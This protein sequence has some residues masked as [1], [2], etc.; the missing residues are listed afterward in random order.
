MQIV[1]HVQGW[2][3]ESGG[4]RGKSCCVVRWS[5]ACSL[6]DS[7]LCGSREIFISQ[8][9]Y[10]RLFSGEIISSRTPG[11]FLLA[12][13]MN[14]SET[15]L[16]GVLPHVLLNTGVLKS[17]GR[18]TFFVQWVPSRRL[19]KSNHLKC[20]EDLCSSEGIFRRVLNEAVNTQ[21]PLFH[22]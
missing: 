13:L 16:K 3:L 11:T 21:L 4:M 1:K 22:L 19:C 20:A 2:L 6:C 17:F 5:W 15:T 7:E 8:P 10:I 18:Y 9:G 12:K 14:V